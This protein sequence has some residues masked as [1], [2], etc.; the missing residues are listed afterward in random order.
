M[1]RK[2]FIKNKD[3]RKR[4]AH[5]VAGVVILIHAF[6]KYDS[7]HDSYKFFTI[8]GIVFLSIAVFHHHLEKKYPWVDGV[9]LLIEAVLSFIVA[10]DFFHM[11]KK[12]LPY[13]YIFLGIFQIVMAFV[14]SK[15]GI[16][17]HKTKTDTPKNII[18]KDV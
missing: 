8:A 4:I 3:K 15:K 1:I 11:G 13:T 12:A 17:A 6:E 16:A 14:R 2:H 9:F 18:A 7:G 5:I 10:L